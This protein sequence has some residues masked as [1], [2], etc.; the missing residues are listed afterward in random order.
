MRP[1]KWTF[2][3][4]FQITKVSV[5]TTNKDHPNVCDKYLKTKY[6]MYSLRESHTR[7]RIS[8]LAITG[9]DGNNEKEEILEYIDMLN[10]STN[11]DKFSI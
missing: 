7:A 2:K 1:F 5:L 10:E 8:G 3:E 6:K 11:G 9:I 4:H